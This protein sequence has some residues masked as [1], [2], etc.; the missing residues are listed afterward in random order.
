MYLLKTDSWYVE[1]IVYLVAGCVNGL[2]II[3]ILVCGAYWLILTGFVSVNLLVFAF[4][5]FCPSAVMLE[6]A[7]VKGLLRRNGRRKR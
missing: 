3:L 7:G 5:G 2:S 1:R 6:K 4:T